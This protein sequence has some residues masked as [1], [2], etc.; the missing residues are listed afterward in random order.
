MKVTICMHVTPNG[1]LL[2][3]NDLDTVCCNFD[4]E[5]VMNYSWNNKMTE[6]IIKESTHINNFGD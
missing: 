4:G 1:S 6:W 3:R 5:N 2:E